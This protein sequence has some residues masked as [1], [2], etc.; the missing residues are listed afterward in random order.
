MSRVK[1]FIALPTLLIPVAGMAAKAA[2]AAAP[3]AQ[4][5]KPLNV[6]CVVCEDTGIQYFG[7]YGSKL[8]VTPTI[9]KLAR[10]GVRYT[11]FFDVIGVSAPSRVALI[12]GVYPTAIGANN[13]RSY[14]TNG[15]FPEGVIPYYVVPPAGVKCYPE[16]LRAA[17]YYC[18][19]NS[20]TDYQFPSPLTAWDDCSNNAEWKHAPAGM[21]FLAIYNFEESHESYVW[22]NRN[23]PLTVDPK[24]VPVPPYFPATDTVRRDIARV[25]S[26]VRLADQFLAQKLKELDDAGKTDNTIV[27][28]YSDNGGPLL[29][30]KRT[31]YE[32]GLHVPLIIRYPK[33]YKAGTVEDRI[34]SFVDIPATIMS[35]IG[36]RPPIYM[37]GKAFAGKYEVKPRE[38]AYA[39]QDR[40]DVYYDKVGS[41]RDRRFIYL[42]N[43]MPE[44]AGYLDAAYR[45]QMP[46]MMD[47]LKERDAG[48]LDA[49]QMDYFNK[50]RPKEEFYDAEADPDNIHNL[51]NDKRYAADIDRLRRAHNQWV[52]DF[53]DLWFL[54]EKELS[55]LMMPGGV[56]RTVEPLVVV[57]GKDGASI[58]CPT[59]G[60]SI[61]YQINGKGFTPKHWML[62]TKPLALKKG[63]VLTA[64][65]VRAGFKNSPTITFTENE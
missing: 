10:D 38:Y 59:E 7:C 36:M 65:G 49:V 42:R 9:D 11:H 30:Q 40:C 26:N 43:Y 8:D 16:Y 35:L 53:N 44:I 17:G 56:Q 24:D 63:D 39:A 21:P 12:T 14:A 2:N 48:R 54:P 15:N 4:G 31:V 50:P 60:S 61:A 41:V 20:K 25:F 62:Y 34:C 46:L 32:Q 3:A 5:D 22:V 45:R 58:F 28:F 19:N 47:I 57:S 27:I 37:H 1:Q 6:L 33:G 51:I 23:K 64:I 52:H 18:T 13:M 55:E 29:R